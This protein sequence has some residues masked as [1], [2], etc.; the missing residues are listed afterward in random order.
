MGRLA[1]GEGE[2][3]AWLEE[4]AVGSKSILNLPTLQSRERETPSPRE[5][6]IR[7][8]RNSSSTMARSGKAEEESRAGA[9]S[10]PAI[11][12]GGRRI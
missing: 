2:V 12:A 9:A 5:A 7:T 8:L 1:G 3:G 4:G 6:A 10:A 11:L